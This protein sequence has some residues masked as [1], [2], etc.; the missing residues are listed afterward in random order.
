MVKDNMI[1][2]EVRR[3]AIMLNPARKKEIKDPLTLG[4]FFDLGIN[5][6]GFWNNFHM[7]L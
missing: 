6:E 1:K 4:R 7:A 2:E 5:K 3:G